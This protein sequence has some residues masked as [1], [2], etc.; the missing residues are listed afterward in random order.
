MST[1]AIRFDAARGIDRVGGAAPAGRGRGAQAAPGFDRLLAQQLG[2]QAPAEPL[3]WSAHAR[4][5]L[6][7]RGIQVTPEVAQRLED[8]VQT[9]AS[10]GSRDSLVM[11]DDMAFVVSVKNRVVIT[12]VDQA[13]MKEQVFTNIDSAVVAR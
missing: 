7:Q 8:A 9:A 1:D 2:P 3:R 13:S 10:K 5:R 4:D 12:A 6:V 11:V